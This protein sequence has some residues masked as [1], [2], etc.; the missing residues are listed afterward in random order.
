M[1]L[2][3]TDG[4][5]GVSHS[6]VDKKAGVPDGT[7]SFYFRTRKA[8][9]LAIAAHLNDLD[10]ADL[11]LL[12]QNSSEE[13]TGTAGC[14]AIVMYSA[15]QP[16]L[17]RTKARYE[18]VLQAGR[19]DE[20]AA[21][22]SQSAESFYAM[23]R[24]AVTQ[25]HVHNPPPDP[26]IVDAQAKTLLT[27]INGVMMTFVAGQPLVDNADQLDRLIQGVLAGWPPH[28]APRT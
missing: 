1:E 9:I 16:G 28:S 11:A 3:G 13:F 26:D 10:T 21:A 25:W 23:A 17:T 20:V 12:T 7:T 27:F 19:D 15:T 4:A 14:A 5:R 18:L 6:K 2:L 22:L 24:N 8:L